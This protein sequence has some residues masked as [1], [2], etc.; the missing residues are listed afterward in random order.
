MMLKPLILL[1]S[2]NIS[3]NIFLLFFTNISNLGRIWDKSGEFLG[4]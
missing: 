4:I 2:L 3:N 1:D